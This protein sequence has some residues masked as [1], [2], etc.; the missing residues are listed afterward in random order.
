MRRIKIGCVLL[1]LVSLAIGVSACGPQRDTADGAKK[2]SLTLSDQVA[3]HAFW[4]GVGQTVAVEL[5]NRSTP[6]AASDPSIL[7]LTDS[8]DSS[9]GKVTIFDAVRPGATVIEP[10][11]R[12]CGLVACANYGP[13]PSNDEFYILV[14]DTKD[15][16][17]AVLTL[18]DHGAMVALRQDERAA[19][20]LPNKAPFG[21]WVIAGTDPG[22][23][24]VQ[25]HRDT[26]QSFSWGIFTFS[27]TG[28]PQIQAVAN[29]NC[30]PGAVGCPLSARQFSVTIWV[31]A[32]RASTVL[33]LGDQDNGAW[34]SLKAG[35]V[36]ELVLRQPPFDTGEGSVVS[37]HPSVLV[38]V[39]SSA[40]SGASKF[41]FRAGEGGFT[42]LLSVEPKCD[43]GGNGPC[44]SLYELN[45]FV[46]P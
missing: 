3:N 29:P 42:Q 14:T 13:P 37:I 22:S 28:R 19:L 44:H 10:G 43:P 39:S 2:T 34:V 27:G 23:V 45:V 26:T 6:A 35:E 16:V 40:P 32:A 30:T 11:T 21:P 4:L 18:A 8:F 24:L 5:I 15:K 25:E 12:S 9:S 38:K 36:I 17:T 1:G 20:L 41:D 33:V 7:K 46:F 31:V